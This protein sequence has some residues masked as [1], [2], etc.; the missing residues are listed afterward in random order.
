MRRSVGSDTE[1][2]RR[3]HRGFLSSSPEG[4]ED[5]S[6]Q[7]FEELQGEIAALPSLLDV[8]GP[9]AQEEV[10]IRR[11]VLDARLNAART[12]ASLVADLDA[13]INPRLVWRDHLIEWRPIL[14]NQL[15]ACPPRADTR[16][17]E[18]TRLGLEISIQAIDR[19]FNFSGETYPPDVL[20]FS[21]MSEVGYTA[22][23]SEPWNLWRAGYG[24]LPAVEQRLAELQKL[25]DEAQARLDAALRD[26][27]TA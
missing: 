9:R 21:M 25:R 11:R 1:R 3:S 8:A 17:A 24:S 15:Q 16:T 23:P 19:G 20:L 6:S 12:A 26:P 27:V 7:R 2:P 14:A 22:P 5:A 18:Y 4:A 10:Y 13:E